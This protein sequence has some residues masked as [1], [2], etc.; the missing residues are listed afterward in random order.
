MLALALL[1]VTAG[2]ITTT[3]GVGGGAFLVACL[4]VLWDPL[5]A[6]TI[7]SMALLCGNAQRLFLFRHHFNLSYSKS[8]VLGCIPGALGGALLASQAPQWL[9]QVAIAVAA[10]ASLARLVPR[11]NFQTPRSVLGP[12][13]ALVGF[14][15]ATTGGGGF[16]LG[17][18][19]LSAGIS[20]N[21]Y[22]ATASSVGVAT[23]CFR[24]TGYSSSG[25]IDLSLLSQAVLLALSIMIGN[26]MGRVIRQRIDP[27][28]MIYLEYATPFLCALIALAGMF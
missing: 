11:F 19:L 23:H 2:L 4:A 25:L 5:T 12:A 6:L 28:R 17:P 14:L 26:C 7:S 20:G 16:L 1:G 3:S 22:I 9:L 27:A 21:T 24:I 15:S 10:V 18:L 8:V 13:S